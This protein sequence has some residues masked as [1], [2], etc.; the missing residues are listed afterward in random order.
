MKSYNLKLLLLP[1][2]FDLIFVSFSAGKFYSFLD[3]IGL[4]TDCRVEEGF[5][6]FFFLNGPFSLNPVNL[7]FGL[8]IR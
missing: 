5:Q 6:L 8:L 4:W 2:I 1:F 7:N 3:G